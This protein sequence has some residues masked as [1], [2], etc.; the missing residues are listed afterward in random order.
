[1]KLLAA[2]KKEVIGKTNARQEK[3]NGSVRKFTWQIALRAGKVN[4]DKKEEE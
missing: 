2:R 3:C 4:L 1:M